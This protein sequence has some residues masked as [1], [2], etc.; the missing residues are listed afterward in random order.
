LSLHVLPRDQ[1]IKPADVEKWVKRLCSSW[2]EEHEDSLTELLRE[3]NEDGSFV[4]LPSD[5][6]SWAH[7]VCWTRFKSCKVLK[8]RKRAA[9]KTSTAAAAAAAQTADETTPVASEAAGDAQKSEL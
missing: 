7:D 2:V 4:K 6:R 5:A 3:K 1:I 8:K 9:P